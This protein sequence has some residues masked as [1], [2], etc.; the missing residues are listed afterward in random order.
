MNFYWSHVLGTFCQKLNKV[1][2]ICANTSAGCG[3]LL[4]C[5]LGLLGYN[6]EPWWGLE[7]SDLVARGHPL[8]QLSEGKQAQQCGAVPG[9]G[10]ALLAMNFPHC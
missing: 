1:N 10:R 9:L 3:L 4:F 6:S 5:A 8:Y 7:G 2:G